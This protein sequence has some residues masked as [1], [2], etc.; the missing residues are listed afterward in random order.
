MLEMV[1]SGWVTSAALASAPTTG[2]P[3]GKKRTT[4]GMS[5]WPRASGRMR[6]AACSGESPLGKWATA[7]RL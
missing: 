4:L 2:G 6:G 5:V 3:E 7:A 1:S